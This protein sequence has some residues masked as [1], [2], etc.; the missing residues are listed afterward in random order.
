MQ[1]IEGQGLDAVLA[2]V[3]RLRRGATEPPAGGTGP[4]A[5]L[6]TGVA[7]GL[8]TGRFRG[9]GS[10]RPGIDRRV[11][12]RRRPTA[13]CRPAPAQA[14]AGPGGR[15]DSTSSILGPT[16]AALL[17]QRGAAGG[18]GGRGAGARPRARHPAPRHQ[19]GQHPAGHAGDRL[20]DRLRPGQGG[21]ERRA[22]EPR[23]HRRHAPL[24]G[25]RAVPRP[26]RP[27]ERHL[28]PGP[29]ALRDAH[30]RAGVRGVGA[31]GADR[32]DDAR[33][34]AAA[35]V[36]STRRSPATWRRSS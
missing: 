28:Q 35:R 26:I 20:G 17:P 27:A 9:P 7:Q 2:E 19:A 33:G 1:Y 6:A 34:A 18:A 21:G 5:S 14:R 31:G 12:R 4:A 15:V 13:R 30:H 29:D 25:A 11:R 10:P 24:H 32:R 8:L 16:E 3:R 22:D 23:R 36:P